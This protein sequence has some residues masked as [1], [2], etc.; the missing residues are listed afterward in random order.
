MND[1]DLK[2]LR[3]IRTEL[4]GKFDYNKPI[5]WLYCAL[6]GKN[7][8][9]LKNGYNTYTGVVIYKIKN[10]KNNNDIHYEIKKKHNNRT[11]ERRKFP[12]QIYNICKFFKS[13]SRNTWNNNVL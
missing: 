10:P 4:K 11:T 9:N 3:C 12:R 8:R 1:I 7:V 13:T 2:D 5:Q 6:L